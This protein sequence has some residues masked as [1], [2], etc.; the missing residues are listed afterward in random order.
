MGELTK[1]AFR[2]LCAE[3][4]LLGLDE[5]AADR[6]Y[7]RIMEILEPGSA[8][9][10]RDVF[11]FYCSEF[12]ARGYGEPVKDRAVLKRLKDFAK[13]N[14]V[15]RT[16]ELLRTY[17]GMREREFISANYPLQLFLLRASR[18]AQVLDTGR[19]ATE[20]EARSA[21]R[22]VANLAAFGLVPGGGRRGQ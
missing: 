6:L 22:K 16:V 9:A 1:A 2:R 7:A 13:D 21:E 10:G 8:T 17:L 20:Q 14:G 15:P 12:Q 3:E 5:A 19:A 11:A 18:I 4:N